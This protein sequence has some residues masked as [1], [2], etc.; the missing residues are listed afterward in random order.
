MKK[1]VFVIHCWE[2]RPDYA[3]Y[4]WLK[5]ELEGHGFEVFVPAMPETDTPT[6]EKW[7]AHLVKTAGELRETDIFIGHSLGCITILHFLEGLKKG[8]KVGG[9]IFVAGF[10]DNL[11]Y[12]ELNSFFATP[13]NFEKIKS[14]CEKFIVI[15]SDNDPYVPLKHGG[16]FK[17]KLGA[18][19]IKMHKMKHFSG[20]DG[21]TELPVV[22]EE[23]INL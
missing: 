5:K 10:T 11:G 12:Q 6:F 15:H 19:L 2:G 22:L 3:W 4:P 8:E 23:L 14:R 9:V 20:D 7:L 13:I 16:I 17:E 1:R 18:K 21:I